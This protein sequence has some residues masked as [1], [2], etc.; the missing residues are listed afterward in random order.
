MNLSKMKL[1]FAFVYGLSTL[2]VVTTSSTTRPSFISSVV[3]DTSTRS[4]L[5]ED[6]HL[7]NGQLQVLLTPALQT[8]AGFTSKNRSNTFRPE[9]TLRSGGGSGSKETEAPTDY[10]NA[11][12]GLFGNIRIPAA[13]FAGAAAG[14]IFAMP[15]TPGVDSVR[16]A[17]V[18]RIYALLMI[19]A[20]CMEIIA[21]MV[22]TVTMN[23]VQG[24]TNVKGQ[25]RRENTSSI[26]LFDV[27]HREYEFEWVS[28]RCNFTYGILQFII[29]IGIRAWVSIGCPVIGKI[30]LGMITSSALLSVAFIQ[31]AEANFHD[32]S[33]LY[34]PIK[35]THLLVRKLKEKKPMF[36]LA[37]ISYI[38]TY[39]Y[40]GMSIPHI[41]E[42]LNR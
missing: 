15:L 31:E 34:V 4:S 39:I 12:S 10:T 27:I 2:L 24:S 41:Y 36:A 5:R 17:W 26:G 40:L 23:F 19:S 37:V 16:A 8:R 22:S 1:S 42:Y 30:G 20:L 33:F 3:S 32:R 14:S 38:V 9:L 6:R 29:A 28:A 25:S 18:K 7:S 13:L 11:I 35:F 21:I